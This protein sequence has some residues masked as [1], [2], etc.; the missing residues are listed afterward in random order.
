VEAP[1][2]LCISEE[3]VRPPESENHFLGYVLLCPLL[4]APNVMQCTR[5]KLLSKG[6]IILGHPSKH[7]GCTI[8][9]CRMPA[10]WQCHSGVNVKNKHQ[11]LE[12]YLRSEDDNIFQHGCLTSLYLDVN[13]SFECVHVRVGSTSGC[14][15]ESVDSTVGLNKHMF[16]YQT[17]L[18]TL[19][20]Q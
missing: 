13:I 5:V 11:L 18:R 14:I 17:S 1:C 7:Q 20:T 3:G 4:A 12:D 10:D 15:A 8:V 6:I 16:G 9:S 2:L 19:K